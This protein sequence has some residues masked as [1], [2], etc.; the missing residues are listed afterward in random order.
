MKRLSG[1]FY[2][3]PV[4]LLVL[5]AKKHHFL[6]LFWVFLA[7]LV[8]STTGQHYGINY[9][10]LDPEYMGEVDFLSFLLIGAALGAFTMTWN[11]TSYILHAHRFPFLAT[12]HRPF[13][14]FML[15]NSLIPLAFLVL[16][17]VEMVDFQ[18]RAEFTNWLEISSQVMGLLLG[19]MIAIFIN[20]HIYV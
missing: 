9:L 2:S 8:T 12:L 16:Y 17:G 13:G 4:Q 19:L 1:I 18:R 14:V 10:Y 6:L 15:N 20:N 7:L 11:I 3:F 5:H